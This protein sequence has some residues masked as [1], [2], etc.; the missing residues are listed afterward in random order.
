MK[1]AHSK[2]HTEN[3]RIIEFPLVVMLGRLSA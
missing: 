2:T 3:G 1:N